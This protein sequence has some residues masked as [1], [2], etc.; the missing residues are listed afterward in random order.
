[1]ADF[2]ADFME[3]LK[4][5]NPSAYDKV[6][7]DNIKPEELTAI[8]NAN[9]SKFEV[10][11]SIPEVIRNR[12]PGMPVPQDVMDAAAR[13]EIYTLREMEYHP[14][15]KRV[16][17]ARAKAAEE[18][19]SALPEL[20]SVAEDVAQLTIAT[21]I[22]AKLAGYSAESCRDLALNRMNREEMLKSKP[23][24][25]SDEEKSAWMKDWLAIRQKD[26]STIKKDWMEHQPE[27]YLMHL[28]GKHNRGRLTPEEK[29]KFPQMV[30][31]LMLK[32]ESENRM[33][34]LLGHIKNP[35][36]QARIGRF[37]EETMEILKHTVLRKVP[38]ADKEQYLARDFAKRREE[39]RNMPDSAKAKLLSDSI[40]QHATNLPEE[41]TMTARER[42]A[43]MPSALNQGMER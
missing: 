17:E 15:I 39:L 34:H 1:M 35:R 9:V 40:N 12:Y 38:E 29:E 32:I 43:N 42:F 26:F 30:E 24:N 8:Y 5:Y 27:K 11:E 37:N 31:D 21:Y 3:Y 25:M 2:S 6:N 18:Y 36:M 33:Q 16:D 22:A 14:E 13:G 23:D 28:L 19:G 20:S 10:W 4:I 41:R 7:S